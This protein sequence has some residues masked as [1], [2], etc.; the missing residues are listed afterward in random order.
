MKL[1]DFIE[2]FK[3][4]LD[5]LILNLRIPFAAKVPTP[6]HESR[7][8]ALWSHKNDILCQLAENQIDLIY[9]KKETLTL[10]DKNKRL[11]DLL[12]SSGQTD[13]FLA[14]EFNFLLSRWREIVISKGIILTENKKNKPCKNTERIS[15]SKAKKLYNLLIQYKL[16]PHD[17]NINHFIKAFCKED[18][19]IENKLK[20]SQSD[21]LCVYLIDCLFYDYHSKKVNWKNVN[22]F[23]IKN[24]DKKKCNYLSNK[25]NNGKPNG[26]ETIDSILKDI[27]DIS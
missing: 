8:N 4:I 18:P 22:H 19:L 1:Y 10:L 3:S 14:F 26:Y 13:T 20:W 11:F 12:V 27:E 17:T 2:E 5:S 16:I 24:P 9:L 21:V 15:E 23:G 25:K 7:L 6:E